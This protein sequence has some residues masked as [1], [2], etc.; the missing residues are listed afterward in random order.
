MAFKT[1][2]ERFWH[3]EFGNNYIRRNCNRNTLAC[4][5]HFFA[6]VFKRIVK[7]QS[8]IEFGA[9][10]GLN[11]S[12]LA[13]LFHDIDLSAVEINHKA[14]GELKRNLDTVT[15]YHQSILD[16]EPDRTWD[17]AFTKGCLIHINPDMLS[18]V[19]ELLYRS[20]GRYILL[21]EYYN[22]KPVD[23]TYRGHTGKLFKRDFAGDMLDIY[24]DLRLCDYGFVYRRD[25]CFPQDDMT[26]F[27]MEKQRSWTALRP[28]PEGQME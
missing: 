27:L 18:V 9:N 26:W 28:I 12:A 1:E 6:S 15:I 10:I 14:V 16:F 22:P 11:L 25:N 21:S 2:Q 13:L 8:A 5:T 19:Y 24:D 20:S 7:I 23:V 17:L 4:N 3:G